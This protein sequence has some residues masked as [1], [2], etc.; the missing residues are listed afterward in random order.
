MN[1]SEKNDYF[2]TENLN[3][4]FPFLITFFFSLD[5]LTV[6]IFDII[7]ILNIQYLDIERGLSAF[8]F[9]HLFYSLNKH[10]LN[11]CMARDCCS[12]QS[13][14]TDSYLAKKRGLYITWKLVLL[15]IIV[16]AQNLL[17]C[18]WCVSTG[19]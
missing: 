5:S 11:S 2:P 13:T 4:Y 19:S 12:S 9:I 6:N 8:L 16:K 15:I 1:N 17:K 18:L 10:S 7:T 3:I 14:L